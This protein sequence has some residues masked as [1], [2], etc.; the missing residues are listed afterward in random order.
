MSS[1][2]QYST[3]GGDA[4][5]V[6][7]IYLCICIVTLPFAIFT[8]WMIIDAAKHNYASKDEKLP[9]L[10]AIIFGGLIPAIVYY[11]KVKKN[12][13]NVAVPVATSHD[14]N[15]TALDKANDPI[16]TE[17]T[18]DNNSDFGSSNE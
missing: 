1:T 9:W 7:F 10:L 5:A 11:V 17:S 16:S 8:I 3:S 18:P 15:N 2:Y 6:V 4:I 14:V 12:T 13:S